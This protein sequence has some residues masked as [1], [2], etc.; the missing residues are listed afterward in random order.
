MLSCTRIL[1]IQGTNGSPQPF[2]ENW[3]QWSGII[4]IRSTNPVLQR[5]YGKKPGKNISKQLASGILFVGVMTKMRM[6][7]I[8]QMCCSLM[9]M[10]TEGSIHEQEKK[11]L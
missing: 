6:S 5:I 2:T 4:S 1:Q 10:L 9:P 11:I 7:L 3:K 8:I